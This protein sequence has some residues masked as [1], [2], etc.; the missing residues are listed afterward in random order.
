L[1]NP[2]GAKSGNGS[3]AYIPDR[4]DFIWLDFDPQT[5]HEQAGRRPAL[6]LSA[7]SYNDKAGLVLCCPITSQVKGYVFEVPL[8]PGGT[9]SGTVLAD[10]LK[11]LAWRERKAKRIAKSSEPILQA[12]LAKVLL[13]LN[14][15]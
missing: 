11:S 4:G 1:A 15:P 3:A 5:G 6:V 8:P 12:V 13:L 2:R 7:R 10:Q 9:V 14:L